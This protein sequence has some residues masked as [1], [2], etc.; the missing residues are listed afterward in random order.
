MHVIATAGHVD[1]G[2]ST[3]VRALTGMEPDRWAEERCRG[4]TIDL[5]YAWTD[6]D[7]ELLAFVDV[8]G[9]QRFIGNMLA[10]LGPA[11]AVMFVVAADEGWRAQ[12]E[13]HLA[14]VH[15]LGLTHG[16]LVVTRSD[17]ADPGPARSDSL[18]RIAQSSLGSIDAVTVSG[19]TG[20]GLD[21]LRT[22]LRG[23]L[24][25]LPTPTTDGRV[26]LWIDRSFTVRGAGT[27]VTGTLGSG[28]VQVGQELELNGR[29]YKVRGLQ[30]AGVSVP[31]AGAVSRVA[32]NLRGLDHDD[33]GR[34]DVLLTPS[35]W[36]PTDLVDVRLTGTAGPRE[37][38]LHIGTAAVAVQV[39]TLSDD[40]ARLRLAQRLSLAI[41]DR[42]I[43]RDPGAQSIV[44]GVEVLDVDPPALRRRGDASRRA[45]ELTT[46]VD[47]A[48]LIERYGAIR[49][50]HLEAMGVD[51]AAGS[52]LR[53]GDW[54]ISA[55]EWLR[56][57]QMLGDAIDRHA[58]DNPLNPAMPA[59]AARQI[60]GSPPIAVWSAVVAELGFVTSDG[61]IAR[62]GVRP[63]L[64]AA[65]TGLA[66]L[67]SRLMQSPFRA[68]EHDDLTALGLGPRELKVAESNGRL[69]RV[70]ADVYL[71]PTAPALAMRVL[72]QLSSP[73]TLSQARQA[74]DTTRRVAV[75]LL[76]LLDARGWTERTEASH[77]RVKR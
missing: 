28:S 75:P 63:A 8:P 38:M 58:V 7:G 21:E 73:F 77:R 44:G 53:H 48:S 45:D 20:A 54:L 40:F 3:L 2:K 9:H 56:W 31:R 6:L 47:A 32:V 69:L 11:P 34:G 27:V 46:G 50:P 15:A 67:V 17:L 76:E 1:H 64:G 62:T 33:V 59:E 65:E 30:Q 12:S 39:R 25:Q 60:I 74:L 13:D 19:R 14:A 5:G 10:G 52:A 55:A 61:R 18:A 68:P 29:R 24:A 35:A 23:L 57:K 22:A 49:V 51:A 70:A 72:S 71:L 36:W 43:L 4:M 26:R 37:L 16:L 66:E 42:A 41:G